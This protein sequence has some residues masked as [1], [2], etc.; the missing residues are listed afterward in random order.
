[1]DNLS[2][3]LKAKLSDG[4]EDLMD[5]IKS[6]AKH[7]FSPR[8]YKYQEDRLLGLRPNSEDSDSNYGIDD[9]ANL[10]RDN[11]AYGAMPKIFDDI[12]PQ[13]NFHSST[14]SGPNAPVRPRLYSRGSQT[15][16]II[17][18]LTVM[19]NDSFSFEVD[20]LS[21]L[22]AHDILKFHH[23][24][25]LPGQLPL[26]DP[27]VFRAV[28][29]PTSSTQ[30]AQGPPYL[31]NE[32]K[33]ENTVLSLEGGRADPSSTHF[34]QAPKISTGL[35]N[36]LTS[37]P[38][39][40]APINREGWANLPRDFQAGLGNHPPAM[41]RP[42]QKP[43]GLTNHPSEDYFHWAPSIQTGWGN[44]HIAMSEAPHFHRGLADQPILP[45]PSHVFPAEI[46]VHSSRSVF[47]NPYPVH[48]D[49][50]NHHT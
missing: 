16:D 49:N 43:A 46:P 14:P 11:A 18:P 15:P 42:P 3:K 8:S 35:V 30:Y 2:R 32:D 44:P 31:T 19:S 17:S 38:G 7:R 12:T 40:G 10:Y 23:P 26:P 29:P 28:D 45:E 6:V 25:Y 37:K 48:R 47:R 4:W 27:R 9:E 34:N 5:K 50:W 33:I 22:G 1:M 41:P 36:N 13:P 21:T 24:A 20:H 39:H